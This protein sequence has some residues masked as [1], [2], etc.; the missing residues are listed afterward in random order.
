[1][2]FSLPQSLVA[3]TVLSLGSFLH[4]S[5][6][7][8]KGSTSTVNSRN[9]FTTLGLHHQLA[10]GISI[11]IKGGY[12][13]LLDAS[14]QKTTTS[15]VGLS[16]GFLKNNW[17]GNA[18]YLGVLPPE[19]TFTSAA[20]TITHSGDGGYIW[21]LGYLFS[22]G[23]GELGPSLYYSELSYIEQSIDGQETTSFTP[24]T[25]KNIHPMIQM[26]FFL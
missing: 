4:R 7:I 13:Q 24:V 12:R 5:E 18:T 14:N 15:F 17:F 3:K 2:A 16:L 1:M 10:S 9:Y 23:W 25:E 26:M 6:I 8:P 11:G 21:E 22:T 20:S 19:K